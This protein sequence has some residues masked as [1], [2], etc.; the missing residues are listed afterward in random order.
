MYALEYGF[1][2]QV[3]LSQRA[4]GFCE[5]K[6][7]PLSPEDWFRRKYRHWR[8]GSG[9][10]YVFSAYAPQECPAYENAVLLVADGRR[11]MAL[12]CI[13]LG[14]FPEA[15]MAELRSCFS[16]CLDELEFQVHVLADR[17][18]DRRSLIEDLSRARLDA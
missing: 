11:Q 4:S 9:R 13:D 3:Q 15:R 1:G 5:D 12:A 14:A 7:P 17:D 16:D 10:S 6:A 2:P 8:G 18:R